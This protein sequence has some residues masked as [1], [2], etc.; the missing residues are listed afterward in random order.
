MRAS[1]IGWVFLIFVGTAIAWSI[2]GATVSTRT[3]I[4]LHQLRSQVGELWGQPLH[5]M[6]PAF[7]VQETVHYRDNKGK[8]Q[9]RY[10][11]HDVIPESSDIKVKL[12]SDARRKGLLWYRTYAVGFDATY[13]V[14]HGYAGQ[15]SLIAKFAFPVD[16]AD[17]DN[18]LFAIND[19]DADSGTE[20]GYLK[21]SVRL[22]AGETATVKLRYKSRGLD[23]WTYSFGEGVRQVNNLDLVA[24]T[25]FHNIDFPE[26]SVSPNTKQQTP[27]GWTLTWQST[28]LRTGRHVGVDMP[29][30]VNAGPMVA[31]ITY[32]APVGLLFY[33]A[34]LV[35][36][37]LMRGDNLHP[38]H[39]FFVCGGFFA[40]H[41]LMAYTADHLEL[42][43]TFLICA[44]VSV[45]LVVSYL[46]RATGPGFTLTI[47]APAQLIY[48]IIFS[49][50]FFFKGYTGLAIT[51]ASIVTLAILMHVTAKVDWESRFATPQHTPQPP[52]APPSV[53][54]PRP[55]PTLPD[56]PASDSG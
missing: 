30:Q 11:Y 28:S 47:A 40:F 8:Q 39:Y 19:K 31:R 27:E 5:Q 29:E 2:L 38:M 37:G 21:R 34:V 46:I 33:V 4:S 12:N 54:T 3:E 15:P 22:P 51:V 18:F 23:T 9:T 49:Y 52:E 17:Y 55:K 36:L 6:A 7:A 20:D 44:I 24:T 25:N 1:H 13:T 45:L 50:T 41:L 53:P 32:F 43:R 35:I 56:K 14:K 10:V 42:E 48:L 26:G 16:D